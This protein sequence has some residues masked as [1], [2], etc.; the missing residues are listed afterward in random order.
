MTDAQRIRDQARERKRRERERK[1]EANMVM[2][3]VWVPAHL[4]AECEEAVRKIVT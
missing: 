3:R 2:Y 4:L 1:R